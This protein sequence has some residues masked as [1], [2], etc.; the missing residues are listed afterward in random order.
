M[1]RGILGTLLPTL[2]VG[3]LG[4]LPLACAHGDA[5]R[6]ATPG[7]GAPTQRSERELR[8]RIES[9]WTARERKDHLA[10]YALYD[11][12]YRGRQG[13]DAFLRESVI[14]TRFDIVSHAIA[15]V[16]LES[17]SRARVTISYQSFLPQL[18]GAHQGSVQ[19]TWVKV[20][21][22][23]YKLYEPP[24]LPFPKPSP[25]PASPPPGR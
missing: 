18:G 8:E 6:A 24:A 13:Q 3:G 1:R 16:A 23:W 22:S 9:W 19:E 4:I 12:D 5:A 15:D 17:D 2:A 11:P 7:S 21:G 10:M 20:G 25:P 14:R